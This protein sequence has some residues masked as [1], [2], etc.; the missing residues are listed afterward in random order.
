MSA[1]SETSTANRTRRRSMASC[2]Y[3]G[4]DQHP[5][6]VVSPASIA[7][8]HPVATEHQCREQESRR[9]SSNQVQLPKPEPQ[10]RNDA[11]NQNV[12]Q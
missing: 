2:E 8:G 3:P 9:G 12:V 1:A 11:E 4:D 5:H 6:A 7:K 10:N